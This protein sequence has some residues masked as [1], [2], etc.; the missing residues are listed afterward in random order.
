[1]KVPKIPVDYMVIPL[2]RTPKRELN[3]GNFRFKQEVF[4]IAAFLFSG[5][6]NA[7]ALVVAL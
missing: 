5:Q 1:M 4:S 2:C 3:A 7:F 6:V